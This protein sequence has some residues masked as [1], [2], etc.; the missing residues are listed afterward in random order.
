MQYLI[1]NADYINIII[2]LIQGLASIGVVIGL[3]IACLQ[4]RNSSKN[5]RINILKTEFDAFEKISNAEKNFVDYIEHLDLEKNQLNE[6]N[7][8]LLNK[9]REEY[10][11]TLNLICLYVLEK[12]FTKKHFLNEYKNKLL[13]IYKILKNDNMLDKYINIKDVV[14]KY[15]LKP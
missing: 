1:D 7:N 2:K 9:K 8:N 6:K 12:C 14:E 3:I 11:K 5:N 4:L 13:K 10:Y 15:N